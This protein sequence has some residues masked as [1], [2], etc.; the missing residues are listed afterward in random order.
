MPGLAKWKGDLWDLEE[1][2]LMFSLIQV[3][4]EQTWMTLQGGIADKSNKKDGLN[5]GLHMHSVSFHSSRGRR[6]CLVG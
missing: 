4:Q 5:R 1:I 3:E 6:D 2:D